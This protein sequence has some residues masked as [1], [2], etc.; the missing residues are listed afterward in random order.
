MTLFILPEIYSLLDH[1]QINCIRRK[2]I[3]D[4]RISILL[5]S[6]REIYFRTIRLWL[7]L[8]TYERFSPVEKSWERK[9]FHEPIRIF[10][11]GGVEIAASRAA[12]IDRFET[13]SAIVPISRS[14]SAFVIKALARKIS[15]CVVVHLRFMS[16][17]IRV[18]V[19]IHVGVVFAELT[20]L[21]W[22]ILTRFPKLVGNE[23]NAKFKYLKSDISG[24][25][26]AAASR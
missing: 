18:Y 19:Y 25:L 3:I 7:S 1:Y 8:P 15:S 23:L 11:P 12:I 20:F 5:P 2:R 10:V 17:C 22:R 21:V 9:F 6:K 26:P 16:T 13:T 14:L 24:G 4:Q